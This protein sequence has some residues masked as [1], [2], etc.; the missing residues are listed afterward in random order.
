MAKQV[1]VD[2]G[3]SGVRLG[4]VNGATISQQCRTDASSKELLAIAIQEFAKD[5][6]SDIAISVPGFVDADDG[7]VRLSRVAPWLEGNL[8]VDLKELAGAQNVLVV[9]D[10]E[11]HALSM[12]G[13]PNIR[14]GAICISLGTSV[15]FGAV[16]KDQNV[17]RTLSG[18]NWD[19]GELWIRSQATDPHV[20]W[21]LGSRGL[22]ELIANMSDKGFKHY[23]YRLGYTLSQLSMLFRPNTIALTGGIIHNNWDKMSRQV[24][25]E[26]EHDMP[27]YAPVPNIVILDDKETVLL[28]LA[29]LLSGTLPK[30]TKKSVEKI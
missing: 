4:M 15:S 11:A 21:S 29:Q 20:W 22:E 6:V 10:G 25:S 18:E 19:I 13:N 2:I 23:G 14:Y 27:S 16:N 17:I 30:A 8:A 12:L 3:G 28:G 26:L 24:V 9:N 7:F 5:D 1:A